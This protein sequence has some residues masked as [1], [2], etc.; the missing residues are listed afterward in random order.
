MKK[1]KDTFLLSAS[2]LA[3]HL[4]CNHLTQL[5]KAV[6][7]GDISAPSW[8]NPSTEALKQRGEELEA[9]YLKS[10]KDAGLNVVEA[11]DNDS[12]SASVDETIAAMKA[13]VDIIYQAKLQ[14]GEWQ[15]YAD[16]LR[17]T[18]KPSDLGNWSYEVI[19]TKLTQ[20]TKAG[21]VLQICL[22]SDLIFKIQ[23]VMPDNMY[24]V[25][26][27]EEFTEETY[28]VDDF[29]SY[30]RLVQTNM[31]SDL[32]DKDEESA[33][34]PEPVN[35][36]EIC[37]WWQVCDKRRR[38]DDHLCLVAG[39]S[40]GQINELRSWNINSLEDLA[41]MSIPLQQKPNKGQAESYEK[42]REQ[43]RVQ[44]EGRTKDVPVFEFLPLEEDQGLYKLPEPNEADI[45][46]DFEGDRFA[47]DRGLE[48]LTGWVTG[49]EEKSEYHA[50]WALDQAEEKA[51][52]TKFIKHV[53][54]VWAENPD[55]HIYHFAHYETTAI[56]R[57]A[58]FYGVYEDEIDELLRH[59]KFVDLY[60]VAKH[61]IRASVESYSIKNLEQFYGFDR[62]EELHDA[63]LNL[64]ILERAIE[65][66]QTDLINPEAK[67]SVELYNKDDCL[68]TLYLRNWLERLRTQQI[69]SGLDITRPIVDVTEISEDR[70]ALQQEIA[71]LYERL[72]GDVPEEKNDRSQKQ[73]ANWLLANML[74][75]Y[76]R[77]KKSTYWELYRLRDLADGEYL[78]EKKAVSY[79]KFVGTVEHTPRGIP[80]D[81]YSY[82]PQDCEL[83]KKADLE[84]S[85]GIKVGKLEAIDKVNRTIDIKKTG[86]TAR[87]HPIA[88]FDCSVIPDKPKPEAIMR[89]ARWVADHGMDSEEL[90][91]KATRELLLGNPPNPAGDTIQA[92]SLLDKSIKWILALNRSVL[93]IQGPPGAGKTFTG[94]HMIIELV[95]QGKKVGVTALSHKVVRNLMLGVEKHAK[96]QQVKIDCLQK[97]SS[98]FEDESEI[99]EVKNNAAV[100]KAL[101]DGSA[102]VFGGVPWLWAAEGMADAVD[103]LFVDEAGQLSLIDTLTVSQAAKSLVLLGDPQQL[104]QP[105]QGCHPSGTE[106]SALDHILKG[107]ETIH[108]DKGLFLDTTWRMHPNVC[109]FISKAFYDN[110]LASQ[111]D[112]HKQLLSHTGEYD[113]AGLHYIPVKH[114]GN[115]SRSIEEVEVIKE[116]I[117]SL[118]KTG[119]QWT[120]KKQET[121]D[122]D[123][124]D[125][126]IIAPYNYQVSALRES[127]PSGAKVGT[128][129]KFQGQ[130]APIV[131]FSLTT[132]SVEDAPRGMEFLY[133]LNRLN[134]A[135]SRAK[136]ATVLVGSPEL[137]EPDCQSPRQM[138]LANAFCGYLEHARVT[139][140][141]TGKT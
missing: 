31:L 40:K 78:D 75:W 64:H 137:F 63:R 91:Y 101:G 24:V 44:L 118:V 59:Q 35:H 115:Q 76:Y 6:S 5:N 87:V 122:L 9:A 133:S 89:L 138:R 38:D 52:F 36:C 14:E 135:V 94:A 62:L 120:N 102:Q 113:G 70:D 123:L 125:I 95:Q 30:Y 22:Y 132:S 18:S 15:G 51:A 53:M 117:G 39:I 71:E 141:N 104:Q 111:E 79:L 85:D 34:Y 83:E 105:L 54:E 86:K 73:H 2:D 139:K 92:D 99:V 116:L 98:K 27:G 103:V 41:Q 47:G 88:L 65:L 23:G 100:F 136:T 109:E 134:V 82:A 16:F 67:K 69:Q 26:P 33:T 11:S 131:I 49:S 55:M 1:N 130:E 106:V 46:L 140:H 68:S 19:D 21:S 127:L 45:F 80:I 60:S 58:G 50:L 20:E 119:S 29:I 96:E 128:V 110:R 56:K 81:R 90:D 37:R 28:R 112:L 13:G 93:P 12:F 7:K 114:D 10:L 43:A 32:N 17:K 121:K 108:E 77:E 48:Y 25:I 8:S 84:T 129:D 61:T 66:G 107:E 126:L 4:S 42:V 3:N 57:M 74:N 124:S 97:V 72:A